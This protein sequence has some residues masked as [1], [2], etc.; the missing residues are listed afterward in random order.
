MPGWNWGFI[1]GVVF[2][3]ACWIGG[4]LLLVSIT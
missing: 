3:L 4:F 2:S 1:G